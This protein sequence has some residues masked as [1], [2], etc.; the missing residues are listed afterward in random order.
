MLMTLTPLVTG[1]PLDYVL[2]FDSA[3]VSITFTITTVVV[4]GSLNGAIWCSCV[5]IGTHTPRFSTAETLRGREELTVACIEG[6]V[7]IIFDMNASL[8]TRIVLLF[9]ESTRWK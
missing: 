8:N 9:I 5:G 4:N 6:H 2:R 7:I 1:P 3:V